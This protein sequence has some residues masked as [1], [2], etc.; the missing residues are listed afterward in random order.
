MKCRVDRTKLCVDNTLK[1]YTVEEID[2]HLLCNEEIE[3]AEEV[4]NYLIELINNLKENSKNDYI[5]KIITGIISYIEFCN[6]VKYELREKD[7]SSIM[8][9]KEI[10]QEFLKKYNIESNDNII[11]KIELL[12]TTLNNNTLSENERLLLNK[13]LELTQ[14][15]NNLETELATIIVKAK[16]YEDKITKL[17]AKDKRLEKTNNELT[18]SIKE[19]K[20]QLQKLQE[21]YDILLKEK[22]SL[23]QSNI[24]INKELTSFKNKIEEI[25]SHQ[26]YLKEQV[27]TLEEK[28]QELTIKLD[29][30]KK[31][32]EKK[33]KEQELDQIILSKLFEGE[34]TIF[35]LYT[36]LNNEG[37]SCTKEELCESLKRIKT[38]ICLS[39]PKKRIVPITYQVSQPLFTT[40][41][42]FEINN[43]INTYDILV[44]SDWHI[45]TSIEIS[46]T[47]SIV[48]S[49]YNYCVYNNI[50][51]IVN[52][53][54]FL[55]VK[56]NTKFNQF[57]DNMKL[58]E[59]IIELFPKDKN[60]IHAIMGGNHDK[61]LLNLG[62]DPLK[63]LE[64]NR[65]DIINLGYD[66]ATIYFMKDNSSELIGLHH[67]SSLNYGLEV[68]DMQ[69]FISTYL[70]NAYKDTDINRKDVYM[71]LFGHYHMT[72]VDGLNHY[73]LVPAFMKM[74][75]QH[76]NGAY[77]FKIYFN[78]DNTINY[79]VIKSI[80]P[81]RMHEQV[82]EYVYQKK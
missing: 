49:L 14:T 41:G 62:I 44:T 45:S 30:Y 42:T 46:K 81:D 2:I 35:G 39:N 73:A 64:D 43:T 75:G 36:M 63:Y 59:S 47:L 15:V 80:M 77:H 10:Y 5:N 60:I 31:I 3:K 9:I 72:R 4:F 12:T 50:G 29:E 17:E 1:N 24:V 61:R 74:N 79:I 37:C 54:D 20:V 25:T 11:E 57:K 16:I 51:L 19:L 69:E 8:K 34:F 70:K 66:D 78:E 22:E 52:L 27:E 40:N 65:R 26:E 68:P 13:S 28:L 38:N 6:E 32:E 67:P 71:D 18:K 48:D 7:K 33:F 55:D 23:E 76:I 53:G 82:S 56:P 21:L 58:L